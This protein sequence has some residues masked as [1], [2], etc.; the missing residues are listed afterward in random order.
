MGL[1][2]LYRHFASVK[3]FWLSQIV[4]TVKAKGVGNVEVSE[5]IYEQKNIK[6]IKELIRV[7]GWLVRGDETAQNVTVTQ[8]EDRPGI[9]L[10]NTRE[11][12]ADPICLQTEGDSLG[13][14]E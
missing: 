13:S 14:V 5:A 1:K 4:N 9:E 7:G 6:R 10:I 11:T 3:F 2:N 12:V 8:P